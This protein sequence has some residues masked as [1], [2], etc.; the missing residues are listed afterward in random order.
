MTLD[1]TWPALQLAFSD[2][3]DDDTRT[4]LLLDV[5][6]VDALALEGIDE[7]VRVTL[8][9]GDAEACDVAEA[10]LRSRG[11]ATTAGISRQDIPDEGWAARS[12]ADL[13]AVV[14]ER[15]A[16]A[17]PWD[18]ERLRRTC[19]ALP[20]DARPDV[21]IIEPSMGFGTGHHQSTRL[22]L[23]ALQ[24][25]DVR[26]L[27]VLD[28]GTGS[29][30]LAIAA[31]RRGARAAIGI[32][33]DPDAIEAA[34]DSVARND[35]SARVTL[36]VT[37]LDDPTLDTADL[38]LANLTGVLLRREGA[39]V[40]RLVASGGRA[41]LSGFTED[42]ARWVADAFDACDVERRFDEDGWVALVLRRR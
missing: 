8:H 22:C 29:G 41:I 7:G 11:W 39:R 9:F 25:V 28:V 26:G 30:V 3:L 24:A 12:Q 5:D 2:A 38:L 20:L 1:R 33:P 13:P 17:P 16:V 42:E 21:I 35:V 6:D 31:I 32:D 14:V 15:L 40:Q 4:R 23:R 34:A 19:E 37:G 36:R 18:V 27:G 10:L